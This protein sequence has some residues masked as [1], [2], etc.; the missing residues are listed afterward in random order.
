[1]TGNDFGRWIVNGSGNSRFT[2]RSKSEGYEIVHELT[3]SSKGEQAGAP[4]VTNRGAKK[5]MPVREFLEQR[6]T[7]T[8]K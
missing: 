3:L 4:W 5:R 6:A 1:V 2:F 8:R 7:A